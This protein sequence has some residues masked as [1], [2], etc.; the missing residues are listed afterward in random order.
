VSWFFSLYKPKRL[1]FI[2]RAMK[3]KAAATLGRLGGKVTSE[4]KASAARANGKKGGRPTK[5]LVA[6]A[7]SGK[8]DGAADAGFDELCARHGYAEAVRLCGK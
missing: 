2:G 6:D 8:E 5:E 4:A 3:N 1:G 7:L